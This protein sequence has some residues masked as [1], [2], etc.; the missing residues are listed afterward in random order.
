M[1]GVAVLISY[2]YTYYYILLSHGSMQ[3]WDERHALIPPD[4]FVT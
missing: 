3:G 2:R 4:D 1:I